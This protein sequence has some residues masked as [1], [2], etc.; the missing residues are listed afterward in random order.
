MTDEDLMLRMM[1][2]FCFLTCK[3]MPVKPGGRG[4]LSGA[5]AWRGDRGES[6]QGE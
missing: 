2:F 5:V 3:P 1:T 6:A 4:L